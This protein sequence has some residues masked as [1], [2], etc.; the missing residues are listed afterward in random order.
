MRWPTSG[1]IAEK[2]RYVI[3]GTFIL[4]AIVSPPDVISQLSVAVPL[5]LAFEAL[6]WSV[7]MLRG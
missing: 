2:R 3:V 6:I 5:L 4:A 7:R 1:R